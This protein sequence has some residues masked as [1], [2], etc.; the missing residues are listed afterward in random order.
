M[1]L[2]GES[3]KPESAGIPTKTPL[4]PEGNLKPP[5]TRM[6]P[7]LAAEVAGP[8]RR[9]TPNCPAVGE[10]SARAPSSPRP[11][12]PGS[13]GRTRSPFRA[14]FKET[15]MTT[16]C[17]AAPA[18]GFGVRRPAGSGKMTRS[19]RGSGSDAL[20]GRTWSA[21]R[22]LLLP[23][24]TPGSLT[25]PAAPPP[26]RQE[27]RSPGLSAP[28]AAAGGLSPGPDRVSPPPSPAEAHQVLPLGARPAR[29]AAGLQPPA[30]P[31]RCGDPGGHRCHR[32]RVPRAHRSLVRA[33]RRPPTRQ[34]DVPLSKPK[35]TPVHA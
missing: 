21:A 33:A 12:A 31:P 1:E 6:G 34:P 18:A 25:V 10:R 16:S 15:V 7:V 23:L 35:G 8:A 19:P 13:R 22:L 11:A 29:A 14:G 30:R 20:R 26:R 24:L 3:G 28:R 9:V 27:G 17:G 5:L 4:Y 32:L 2:E